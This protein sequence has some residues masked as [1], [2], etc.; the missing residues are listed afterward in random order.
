MISFDL[1]NGR[2][3]YVDSLFYDRTYSGLM[4]GKPVKR[5]N[6]AVIEDLKNRVGRIWGDRR[7]HIIPPVMD[8]TDPDHPLLPPVIISVM[9]MSFKPVKDETDSSLLVVSFFCEEITDK[10]LPKIIYEYVRSI[11][12]DDLAED[13][14]W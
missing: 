11:S 5:V 8:D 13:F 6:D 7:H 10:P 1:N 14:Y 9:L 3:V 2:N 12:W 4:E